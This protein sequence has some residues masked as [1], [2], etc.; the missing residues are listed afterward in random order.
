[1]NQEKVFTQQQLLRFDGEQE[2]RCLVAYQGIVYDVTDCP[3]WRSGLHE[4]LHF[5]GLDLT[6]E[7]DGESPHGP[8]V[9]RYPCVKRVGILANR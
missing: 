5:P 6:Q 2:N 1:V 9:F 4:N 3:K 8:E 7:L